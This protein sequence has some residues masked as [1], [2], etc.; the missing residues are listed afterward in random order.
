MLAA[1]LVAEARSSSL[2]ADESSSSNNTVEG[3]HGLLRRMF[4]QS[5][6]NRH[7]PSHREGRHPDPDRRPLFPAEPVVVVVV[8]VAVVL[9]VPRCRCRCLFVERIVLGMVFV[10]VLRKEWMEGCVCD[11][12]SEA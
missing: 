10:V 1:A 2:E 7:G 6:P 8:V 4:Q 5:K 3:S 12:S 9:S 11:R